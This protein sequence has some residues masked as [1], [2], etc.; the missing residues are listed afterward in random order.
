MLLAR[1][2]EGVWRGSQLKVLLFLGADAIHE[3][4][5]SELLRKA[6]ARGLPILPGNAFAGSEFKTFRWLWLRLGLHS[7]ASRHG[8]SGRR[9]LDFWLS[10]EV[11]RKLH[12]ESR[13]SQLLQFPRLHHM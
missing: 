13:E 3:E 8:I 10:G 6:L 1:E 4:R 5:P 11:R 12:S 2:V 9:L 7:L